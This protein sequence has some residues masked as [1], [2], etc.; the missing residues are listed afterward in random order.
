MG[1]AF[2][3]DG[4]FMAQIVMVFISRVYT[5]PQTRQVA[6][7]LLHVNHDSI[8]WGF[9]EKQKQCGLRRSLQVRATNAECLLDTLTPLNCLGK[10]VFLL[11]HLRELHFF[12]H[13]PGCI[14]FAIPWILKRTW[15]NQQLS[16]FF[17]IFPA[18]LSEQDIL[19]LTFLPLKYH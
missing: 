6:Y 14:A 3:G 16:Y 11:P 7:S 13:V 18:L 17:V 12:L 5:Y 8:M 15:G 2:G 1:E 9:L 4:Q 19:V 10:V